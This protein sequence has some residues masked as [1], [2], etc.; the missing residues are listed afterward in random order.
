M[1]DNHVV[2]EAV[3]IWFTNSG[4]YIYWEGRGEQPSAL[5]VYSKS[6]SK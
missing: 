1:N 4:Q 5:V 6:P 3:F 2:V